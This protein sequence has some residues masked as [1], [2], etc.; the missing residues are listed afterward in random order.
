[1]LTVLFATRN[2]APLLQDVLESF[3]HLQ[4]PPFGWKLVLVDN[5]STDRT[6]QVIQSFVGRLPL[7]CLAEPK[8]GKNFALNTG[9]AL[10]EGDLTVFTDD[11][12]FPRAD[13]LVQLRKAADTHTEYTMFGGMI[14]P[15]W[16][17]PP[18]RWVQWVEP[19]PVFTLT[20]PAQKEG[21]L[22]P[23]LV[24]GPNMA[25]RT[26]VFQTGIRFNPSVGPSGPNYAMGGETE[27]TAKLGRLGHKALY[28][29]DAI[30]E[31]FIRKGQLETR[32]VLKRA[33]RYGRGFL[34]L[35]RSWEVYDDGVGKRMDIPKPLIHEII[36][37][38]VALFRAAFRFNKEALFRSCYQINFL[39]GQAVEARS[40]MR[41]RRKQSQSVQSH[42]N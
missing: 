16:E 11:D 34:Q 21:P 7:H 20:D 35:F 33:F 4:E 17:V 39:R 6:S 19:G 38:A 22:S 23:F 41:E 27:L 2:R 3:C 26:N 24:F 10:V 31:H 5:G 12:V 15:R 9:L 32:W 1:M 14:V 42:T 29:P 30:V 25:I 28:V 18:P 13:W 8:L 36:D 37:A 40:L